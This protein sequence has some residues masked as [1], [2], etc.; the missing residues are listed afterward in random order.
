MQEFKSKEDEINGGLS[1]L[2]KQLEDSQTKLM[3]LQMNKQNR[4]V[5]L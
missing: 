2:D 1:A 3:S 4:Y 5:V